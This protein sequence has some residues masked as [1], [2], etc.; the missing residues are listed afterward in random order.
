MQNFPKWIA[1]DLVKSS[2]SRLLP[3]SH[4]VAWGALFASAGDQIF[5]QV[6]QMGTF[7]DSSSLLV[8]LIPAGFN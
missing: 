4:P 6:A 2:K 1:N 7:F 5:E 8:I 3:N